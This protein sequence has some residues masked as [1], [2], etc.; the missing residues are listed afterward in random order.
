MAHRLGDCG[1]HAADYGCTHGLGFSKDHAKPFHVTACRG[2]TRITQDAGARHAT[3]DLIRILNAS[4]VS[5][6]SK[7]LRQGFKL[8]TQRPIAD[9]L[10]MCMRVLLL[11]KCHRAKH[12]FTAFLLDQPPDKQNQLWIALNGN[13]AKTF[14]V[15][16]GVVN[17][18]LL[19]RKASAKSSLTD[20][21]RDTEKR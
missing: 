19:F 16:A 5:A 14:A 8:R 11:D 15:N 2:H 13:W 9:D 6:H 12:V 21:S 1:M 18:K 7:R 3:L 4:E 17:M 10:Q 20:R